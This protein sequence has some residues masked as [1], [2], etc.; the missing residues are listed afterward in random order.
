MRELKYVFSRTLE[1]A[2]TIEK[3]L[4]FYLGALSQNTDQS[5][6][7]RIGKAIAIAPTELQVTKLPIEYFLK[8]VLTPDSYTIISNK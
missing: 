3:R 1:P 5:K 4:K 2:H 6:L 7:L 8:T